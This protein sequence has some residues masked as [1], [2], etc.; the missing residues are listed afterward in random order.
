MARV[1]LSLARAKAERDGDALVRLQV[2]NDR[3]RQE[4]ALLK[5]EIRIKDARMSRLPAQRRP[6][7]PPIER[8]AILALRAARGWSAAETARRLLVTPLTVAAWTGRLDDGGPHALLQVPEPVNRFP[9]FVAHL[10]QQLRAVCPTMGA[11]RIAGFL[12][13]A[14][15]HL[16]AT[17]VR[18]MI[19]PRPIPPE[20]SSRGTRVVTA[21][22]PNHV[23]H[24]DLTTVPLGLGFWIPWIPFSL[25]QRWPF[26]RWI[27]VVVDHFSRKV[28]GIAVFAQEPT[29]GEI[30]RF[31]E[32]VCRRRRYRPDHLIT[33]HGTQFTAEEF[34]AWC[35]RKGVRQRFGAIG[36]Y[37]SLAVIERFIR[38]LK[39]ECLRLLLLPL[40]LSELERQ[41]REYVTWYNENRPHTFLRGAT[42][43]EVYFRKMPAHRKPRFEPRARWPRPSRCAR[44]QAL[45]RGQPGARLELLLERRGGRRH[46][47]VVSLRRVA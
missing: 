1:S 29:A 8:L 20:T 13:R 28:M 2:E 6:H 4:V 31:L 30:V 44:P 3:L 25:P 9:E 5:E 43:D 40:R 26:C 23:W 12:A 45:V 33:D 19:R 15:L 14:G 35:S 17:T 16:G 10:V 11:R 38:S 46:L 42:P 27:A 7:Y 41:I 36:K 39:D 18:R 32:R 37:G 47:P 24:A 22:R 34:Q 21:K